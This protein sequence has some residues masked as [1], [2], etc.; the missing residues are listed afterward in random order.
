M[1]GYRA[2]FTF[3]LS[4]LNCLCQDD[5]KLRSVDYPTGW[6]NEHLSRDRFREKTQILSSLQRVYRL[7][8]FNTPIQWATELKQ[9]ESEADNS[10]QSRAAVKMRAAIL[11][12]PGNISRHRSKVS[13]I[14]DFA[15]TY[16]STI[17]IKVLR[18]RPTW[19]RQRRSSTSRDSNPGPSRQEVTMPTISQWRYKPYCLV[20]MASW[21][22]ILHAP[23]CLI[24]QNLT[25]ANRAHLCILCCSQ[26]KRTLLPCTVLTCWVF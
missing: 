21:L 24:L 6:T 13:H 19:L 3:N 7:R 17:C 15:F 20:L 12:F 25:S 10:S 22:I 14:N 9:P 11:S 26:N 18:K 1:A 23:I 8:P 5:C 2:N 4:C 16:P